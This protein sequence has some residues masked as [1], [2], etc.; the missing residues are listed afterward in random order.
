MP[1]DEYYGEEV[2]DDGLI[3]IHGQQNCVFE[4]KNN[5]NGNITWIWTADRWQ[6]SPDD[7]KGH[8]FQ[9]WGPL[10]WNENEILTMVWM[11]QFDIVF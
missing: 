5:N 9:Y 6:S 7:L 11:D 4:V 2:K 10:V 3:V 8:D 1:L